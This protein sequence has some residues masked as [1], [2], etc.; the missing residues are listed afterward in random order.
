MLHFWKLTKTNFKRNYGNF[1]VHYKDQQKTFGFIQQI[2][3]NFM[4]YF[5]EPTP[6]KH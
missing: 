6:T 1:K 5:F 2:D 3:V 4:F